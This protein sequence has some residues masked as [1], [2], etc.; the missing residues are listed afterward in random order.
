VEFTLYYR[1][2]L[3]A[4]G[5]QAHKHELRQYFHKQVKELWNQPPL[6]R[7]REFLDPSHEPTGI[8]GNVVVTKHEE[9]SVVRPVGAY[10]FASV[11]SSAINLVADLTIDFL[12]PEP[13]GAIVTQGGDIDNRIK[14][15]LDA[16]KMPSEP[17]DLPKGVSPT[18]DENP[19]F[20]CLLED[21]NLITSLNIKTDRLLEPNV[22]PTEVVLLIHVRT[23]PTIGT[24][25][26]L[27]LV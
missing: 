13:P 10:K 4:N 15:L 11:V 17:Q 23:R 22:L 18:T 27:G 20:F 3:K 24:F 14:T 2:P 21:D 12:R 16:L 26:N 6:N 8:S 25:G 7:N 1:G 9:V 19:F 5:T